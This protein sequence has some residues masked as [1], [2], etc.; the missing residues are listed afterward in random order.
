MLLPILMVQVDSGIEGHKALG[1]E[2]PYKPPDDVIVGRCVKREGRLAAA[3][4]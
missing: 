1:F 4:P 2:D 3:A